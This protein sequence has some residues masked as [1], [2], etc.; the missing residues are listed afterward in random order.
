MT[1]LGHLRSGQGHAWGPVNSSMITSRLPEIKGFPSRGVR[2]CL[3]KLQTPLQTGSPYS[4]PAQTHA[5]QL[6]SSH[7][8]CSVSI[9]RV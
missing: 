3:G 1:F 8:A 7:A 2:G 9:P 4:G 6:T 5:W